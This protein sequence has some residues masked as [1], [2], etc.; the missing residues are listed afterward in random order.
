M[1][2]KLQ[3]PLNRAIQELKEIRELQVGTNHFQFEW[4]G[5]VMQCALSGGQPQ[6]TELKNDGSGK[7]LESSS[8]VAFLMERVLLK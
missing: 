8:G 7:L 2:A 5:H 4:R 6:V 1:D 3:K